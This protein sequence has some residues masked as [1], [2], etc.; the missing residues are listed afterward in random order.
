MSPENQKF[1]DEWNKKSST[2]SEVMK[3]CEITDIRIAKTKARTLKK[4]LTCTRED[5]LSARG[6]AITENS[7]SNN[8]KVA[9]K[10]KV[11]TEQMEEQKSVEKG[12][13]VT[14]QFRNKKGDVV[15]SKDV[16]FSTPSQLSDII[17]TFA[18]EQS[19]DK[20]VIEGSDGSSINPISVKDGD[21]IVVRPNISG[22]A[23][24]K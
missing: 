13:K 12:K 24:V 2:L 3:R 18:A 6:V 1:I 17:R 23:A 14:V 4:Y 19:F 15:S 22:A 21:T 5:K 8:V 11:T 10:T 9:S 20:T 16:V 7:S